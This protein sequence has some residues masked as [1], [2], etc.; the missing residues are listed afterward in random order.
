MYGIECCPERERQNG[1]M[2]SVASGPRVCPGDPEADRELLPPAWHPQRGFC[3]AAG[4]RRRGPQHGSCWRRVAVDIAAELFSAGHHLHSERGGGGGGGAVRERK[5]SGS[6]VRWGWWGRSDP[7][8]RAGQDLGAQAS[9]RTEGAGEAERR[10]V[11]SRTSALPKV[12][13]LR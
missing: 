8:R 11:L 2:Y 1:C 5:E 9:L 6:G 13:L 4:G 10:G 7:E 3:G 12:V